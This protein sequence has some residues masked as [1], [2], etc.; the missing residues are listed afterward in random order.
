LRPGSLAARVLAI[1]PRVECNVYRPRR[2]EGTP[3]YRLLESRY[4][5]VKE[6]WEDRFENRYGFWRGMVEMNGHYFEHPTW[7]WEPRN[8]KAIELLEKA[9]EAIRGLSMP[10]A[11]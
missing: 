8:A 9:C 11:A 2:P 6:A 5:P 7:L 1:T 10:M 3:L 4:E